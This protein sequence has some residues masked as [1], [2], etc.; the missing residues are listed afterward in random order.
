MGLKSPLAGTNKLHLEM[1]KC[2][3]VLIQEYEQV[4]REEEAGRIPS[5]QKSLADKVRGAT[6]G[7]RRWFQ[8]DKFKTK[9]YQTRSKAKRQENQGNKERPQCLTNH[10]AIRQNSLIEMFSWILAFGSNR[11]LVA[12]ISDLP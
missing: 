6:W 8:E 12:A 10:V 11:T 1:C 7:E 2:P 3:L 9:L 4:C 5:L